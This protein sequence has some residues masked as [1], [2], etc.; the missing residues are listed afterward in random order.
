MSTI[1][2]QFN[3]ISIDFLTQT[4]SFVGKSYLLKFKLVTTVNSVYGIDL[5]INTVLP[6]KYKIVEK[7]ETFFLNNEFKEGEN[8]MND[9]IGFKKIYHTLDDKS[10]ENLWEIILSLVCL[11]EERHINKS[12]KKLS[13][14]KN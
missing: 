5:F 13:K 14:N 2:K 1:I 12:L 9:I 8:Y 7:D 10:K 4:S 3:E 11:A 6:Y